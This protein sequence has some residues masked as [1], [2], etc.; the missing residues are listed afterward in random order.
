MEKKTH[1]EDFR[2]PCFKSI[3]DPGMI[4]YSYFCIQDEK[5]ETC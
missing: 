4:R 3:N 5:T 2:D 1:Q